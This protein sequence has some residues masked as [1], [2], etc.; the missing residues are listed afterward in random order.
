MYLAIVK[1]K[2]GA[3]KRA[4]EN[5]CIERLQGSTELELGE[6]GE[7]RGV[8]VDEAWKEKVEKGEENSSLKRRLVSY[9]FI[10]G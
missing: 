6:K 5:P 1:L 8:S 3:S 9:F 4:P 2:F 7:K 10:I